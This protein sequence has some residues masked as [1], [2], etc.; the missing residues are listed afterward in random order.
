MKKRMLLILMSLVIIMLGAKPLSLS[1]AYELALKN[2]NAYQQKKA[3]LEAATWNRRAALGSMLPTLSL[4]GSYIYMD[5]ATTVG[6]GANSYTMNNDLRSISLNLSQPLFVGGK[7]WQAYKIA[8]ISEEMAEQS[9]RNQEL[10]LRAEVEEKFL[11]VL[12]LQMLQELNYIQMNAAATN[13]ELGEQKLLSGLISQAEIT[14]LKAEFASNEVSLIQTES[15]LQLAYL[16]LKQYLKID[17]FPELVP[18]VIDEKD[19]LL[20]Y[21][22]TDVSMA[23]IYIEAAWEYA[24]QNN[25]SFSI[26]DA[27][28]ELAKRGYSMAKYNYLPSLVL[29]GSRKFDEN[30]IDRY[31]FS[32]QNQILLTASLPLLP[33]ITNYANSRKAYHEMRSATFAIQSAEDGIHT[34]LQASILNLFSSAKLLRASTLAAEYARTS[35]QQMQFRYE[36][37]MLSVL[38]MINVELMLY[39]A[40]NALIKAQHDWWKSQSKVMQILGTDDKHL[41]LQIFEQANASF[42]KTLGSVYDETK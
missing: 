36:M 35:H 30:G 8:Q 40:E 9:L 19:R 14:R 28:T 24:K 33:Q 38:D 15:A 22:Q 13:L 20:R 1:E 10:A 41:I 12:F 42:L 37:N 7:L 21:M 4:S 18:L 11:S 6:T 5:P 16:D 25:P 23:D 39:A 3:E 31:E 34:A 27:N 32:G 17:F 2:N 26:L 29:T